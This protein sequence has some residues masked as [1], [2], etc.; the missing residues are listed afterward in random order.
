M[1][2]ENKGANK[3]RRS[4]KGYDIESIAPG[5]NNY[6]ILKRVSM[7]RRREKKKQIFKLGPGYKKKRVHKDSGQ[8][9]K[10]GNKVGVRFGE[11][12]K[13]GNRIGIKKGKIKPETILESMKAAAEHYGFS[14][15]EIAEEIVKI[16]L[17]ETLDPK[18]RFPFM[19]EANLRI[20]GVPHGSIEESLQT[21][22]SRMNKLFDLTIPA[23]EA[24][25]QNDGV[26]MIKEL[27]D[28]GRLEEVI[29]RI[30]REGVSE[31]GGSGESSA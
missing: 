29:E 25:A 11:G 3:G 18:V 23:L 16:A 21:M 1:E 30:K 4:K 2:E 19:K 10:K 31:N 8:F 9:F 7:E 28:Q 5:L 15:V 13:V 26:K 14:A 17:D 24:T 12:Q 20:F 27:I 22:N 6:E